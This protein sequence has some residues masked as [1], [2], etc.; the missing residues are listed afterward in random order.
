M[1]KIGD[2]Q[3]NSCHGLSRRSFL[4]AS[5]AL[6]FVGASHLSGHSP[7]SVSSAK[8]KS[9]I[10]IFLWGGPS[11]LD[12]FD[13][14]P[15][16]PID[17]RG[18]FSTIGTTI[19]GIRFSEL[20]PK[21]AAR[22]DKF[23]LVRSNVSLDQGHPGAGTVATTGYKE[24]PEP[25]H[26]C[27]GSIAARH[28]GEKEFPPY[29]MLGKGV[30]RDVVR[31]IKGYGGGRWGKAYDPFMIDCNEMGEVNVP[32]LK[33]LKGLSPERLQERST[34]TKSLE[35]IQKSVDNPKAN[36]WSTT[37]SKAI[38]L[39]TSPQALQS[40]DL[41]KETEKVRNAYGQTSFGQSLLLARR[42]AEKEVPYIH[43]N[44]SEYVEALTP[45][46]DFG[47]DTHIH[48]FDMLPNRHCPI[49]DRALS[50][51]LDDLED[52]GLLDTT[53][54]CCM[55]EFGRTPKINN[56]AARDHWPQCF[57]SIWAGAGIKP[58]RVIGQSDAKAALPV[59][60]PVKP[61]A[62]GATLLDQM[63]INSIVRA[64][65]DVLRDGE[66]ISDLV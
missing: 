60:D 59:T 15:E 28:F 46:T 39:L 40:L 30:P 34:L 12:T 32:A 8:A 10:F 36:Y 57:F 14:K 17:Y 61:T 27:F 64:E 56:R 62:V 11:H 43:V 9:V 24:N 66:L 25:V 53:L 33:V 50:A 19:P 49:L 2:F 48:N 4:T 42:L 55:G 35:T 29:L 21:L 20:V 54:V 16:A 45:N 47:W 51:L 44:W 6:P 1:L 26:P 31:P 41:S 65:L 23:S 13:P 37:Q 52:R 58:G 18:P 3:S 38:S 7:I 22:T 5:A 63:G